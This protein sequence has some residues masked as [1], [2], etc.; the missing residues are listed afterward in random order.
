MDQH[1]LVLEELE[2]RVEEIFAATERLHDVAGDGKSTRELLDSVFRNVHNLKASAATHDLE[3]LARIAHQFENLLHSLRVGK[4]LIGD[5]VLT[6]FDS[7]ADAMH[8]NLRDPNS[9]SSESLE[10]LFQKLQLLSEPEPRGTR[11]EVEVVL[12]AIP[13]DIWQALSAEEK[14]RLEQAVGDGASLYLVNTGFDITD[15]DQL[16]QKLKTKLNEQGELISTAPTVDKQYP[17]KIDFRILYAREIDPEEVNREFVDSADIKISVISPEQSLIESER[18]KDRRERDHRARNDGAQLIRV[19]VD[20]LDRLLS[21]TQHLVR[22]TSKCSIDSRELNTQL[23]GV[24]ASM[25]RLA[26]DLANLRMVSVERLLQRALRA[27]RSAATAAGK[28]VDFFVFDNGVRIDKT[29]SDVIADPLIHLVRN[30]VDHGIESKATRVAAGK[31]ERGKILIEASTSNGR[32][33]IR[34][35]DDG[36]GIDPD[37]ICRTA[38]RLGLLDSS[39]QLDIEQ[40]LRLIFRAGFSTANTVSELSGRGV[41]LDVVE[42]AIEEA[43]GAIR[44]NSEPQVGSVFEI[45]LPVTFSF[46]DVY[47]IRENDSC[48]LIDSEQ[49]LS[50]HASATDLTSDGRTQLWRLRDLLDQQKRSEEPKTI[51]LCTSGKQTVFGLAVSELMGLEQVLIRNLGSRGGRWLGVA[52]AAEMEDG[53]VAIMLDLPTLISRATQNQ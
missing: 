23:A 5:E 32:T 26:D 46:L 10:P 31:A 48:Y 45:L 1:R 22:E 9:P 15:F 30:A 11:I 40:S 27:G 33:R 16:F 37:L 3:T 12:N 17:D 47:V 38:K 51:L 35:T 13:N 8:A 6:V 20:E 42:G 21:S 34:V 28:Q 24:K 41:G 2:D 52:G 4:I 18:G 43:G 14:H 50:T 39:A 49:V 19:N 25:M 7:I 53:K 29:L 44:V 36:R